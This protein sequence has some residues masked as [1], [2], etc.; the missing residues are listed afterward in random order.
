M[1]IFV[2]H[3][4]EDKE[5]AEELV[6]LLRTALNLK[7]RDFRFTSSPGFGIPTG[8]NIQESI[9]QDVRDATVA[10]GLLTPASLKSI[11][12]IFELGARWGLEQPI[13]PICANGV[14]LQSLP[15]PLKSLAAVD[16]TDRLQLQ[17]FVED[18]ANELNRD[19]D[20]ASS[21]YPL[22]DRLTETASQTKDEIKVESSHSVPDLVLEWA[23]LESGENLSTQCSLTS[24][25]LDTSEIRIPE[26]PKSQGWGP[27]R[28]PFKNENF[29]QEVLDYTVERS[30]Y[31]PL[32]V[33]IRNDSGE[34]G[35]RVRFV[36]RI[37]R[38]E[39][40]SVKE[41]MDDPP[42]EH[43][44]PTNPLLQPSNDNED[45]AKVSIRTYENRWSVIVDFGDIRPHDERTSRALWFGSNESQT[46]RLYGE[47]RGDNLSVPIECTL[48]F[49]IEAK[50]RPLYQEDVIPFLGRD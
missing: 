10:I 34:V 25:L 37:D 40:L 15:D 19:T 5:L 36:G 28:D 22:I 50:H 45:E 14:T 44:Y 20:T 3:S 2:S 12:V 6:T 16:C 29:L 32:S 31:N 48:E 41:E 43:H 26:E 39:G 42:E 18:V 11:W 21:Y 47:L 17:K 1:Q 8:S 7:S 4:S 9:R 27:I 46:A 49:S 23:N 24:L 38:A 30:I 33:R 13:F 35:R